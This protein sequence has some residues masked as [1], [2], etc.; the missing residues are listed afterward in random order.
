[1]KNKLLLSITTALTLSIIPNINF[2]QAPDLGTAA[3][4]VLFTSDGA[5]GNTGITHLTGN[6]G[7]NN[8]SSTGFGNVNGSMLNNNG[9][10]AT[11]AADLLTAY[12]NLNGTAATF[13]PAPLLGNGDTLIEGVYSISADATLSDT[14]HF[15]AQGD[16]NAVFIIKIQAPLS[17]NANSYISLL[18]GALACNVFWKVEGLVSMAAGTTM[19][20]NII[21]NN[22]AI[23]MSSGVTLEGRALS[24]T[25]AVSVD[26]VLAYL[27]TGCG[28]PVLSGPSAPVLNAVSC[29]A[30]FSSDGDVANS[31][32]STINGDIGSNTG[33]ATG[34]DSST[35][36]GTVHPIPD[37]ATSAAAADL[38]NV[39]SYLNTLPY[40][41]EL[42]YPAQFGNSL[43]LTPHTYIMN[44]A[45]V[46][47]DTLFLNSEGNNDA[48]F[49]IKINGA[50]I[51]STYAVVKLTNG[52]KAENV[53]WLVEGAV[54]INDY[55]TM[56][57]TVI[58]NNGA[59]SL[60]T[61]AT[62]DGRA[63]TTT[64]AVGTAA[65]NAVSATIPSNCMTVGVESHAASNAVAFYP[66]PF[67]S[68]M[69][70]NINDASQSNSNVLRMYN[71]LGTQVMHVMLTAETTTLET[72]LPSGVYFY[73]VSGAN[74]FVQSGTLISQQ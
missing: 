37:G 41:I 55:S 25:G 13:F 56:V 32:I 14:L 70:V 67:R 28:S 49:V 47:T 11:A 39:Y 6:V 17:T 23:Q 61:G 7:S 64:G 66:N 48:V 46:F 42:L 4:F 43:V 50:L 33:L 65:I 8:G 68:S 54:E 1:M 73:Q 63:L 58:S 12:N 60:T 16:P 51:T 5:M 71:T 3:N 30:I 52:T 36:N 45:T 53:F 19:R 31:G 10:T 18:N 26:N 21:A 74:G 29:F 57:G 35:V 40:D 15:D 9:A 62:I 72:N 24:T 27:P 34:F 2:A 22:A 44:A 20:G 59:V 69:V 38:L